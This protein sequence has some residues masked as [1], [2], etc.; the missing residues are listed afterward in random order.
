MKPNLLLD[1]DGV[2]ADFYHGFADFLNKH[3]KAELDLNVE[4]SSYKFSEWNPNLRNLDIGEASR[5]WINNDGLLNLPIYYGARDFVFDIADMCDI[6][7]V[8]AR[9]GDFIE[10]FTDKITEKIKS[11][12]YS[13]FIHHKIPVGKIYFEHEKVDF[14]EANNIPILVED[15]LETVLSASKKGLKSILINR[16]WNKYQ[17]SPMISRV[18]SYSEAL[19]RIK[20]LI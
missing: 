16:N 2:L 17:D 6:Y 8:T 12:T 18:D 20:E 4:P 3:Y 19:S 10:L 13:W 11:D 15:K 7:I 5:N 1:I 14:C 9:A